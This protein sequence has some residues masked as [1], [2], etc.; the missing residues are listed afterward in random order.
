MP[1]VK[2]FAPKAL[3]AVLM[4][5]VA[6][7]HHCCNCIPLLFMLIIA[8]AAISLIYGIT[9]LELGPT[10][11]KKNSYL[12]HYRLLGWKKSMGQLDLGI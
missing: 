10:P 8:G 6:A 1:R 7:G 9:V 3:V 4:G 5:G 11:A 2:S 12:K